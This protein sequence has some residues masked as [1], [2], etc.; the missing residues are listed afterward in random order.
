MIFKTI[1]SILINSDKNNFDNKFFLADKLINL[2]IESNE[3]KSF[4][5]LFSLSNELLKGND[6]FNQN[7][8]QYLINKYSKFYTGALSNLLE[9]HIRTKFDEKLIQDKF[10]IEKI[11]D[12]YYNTLNTLNNIYLQDKT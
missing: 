5:S 1:K 6:I 10:S 12:D 11:N 8:S 4:E 7:L 3:H 9:N 2:V